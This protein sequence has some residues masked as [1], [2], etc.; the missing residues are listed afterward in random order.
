MLGELRLGQFRSRN[1]FQ[2]AHND[3]KF[4]ERESDRERNQSRYCD[5]SGPTY[6]GDEDE[7]NEMAT[8]AAEKC[9]ED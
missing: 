5:I 3:T 7:T 6:R 4:S 1:F 8:R 9:H 2:F